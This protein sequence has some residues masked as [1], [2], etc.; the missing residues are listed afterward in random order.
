MGVI[1]RLFLSLALLAL[2]VVSCAARPVASQPAP[3]L[4]CRDTD[5]WFWSDDTWTL[6]LVPL[7][8]KA[9][10]WGTPE[11]ENSLQRPGRCDWESERNRLVVLTHNW[12]CNPDDCPVGVGGVGDIPLLDVGERVAL[13]EYGAAWR[14]RVIESE[15]VTTGDPTPQT[16]FD[17]AGDVCGTIVTSVGARAG[18]YGPAAGYWL[19][20]ISY[21]RAR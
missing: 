18:R 12:Y 20:R 7:E 15:M 4:T 17:C 6:W 16:D 13:C 3:D 2:G 10:L 5:V 14:G 11:D 19:V 9:C 8:D 1:R 21:V